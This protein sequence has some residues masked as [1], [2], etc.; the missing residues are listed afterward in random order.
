MPKTAYLHYMLYSTVCIVSILIALIIVWWFS[1]KP[2]TKEDFVIPSPYVVMVGLTADGVV[3]YADIDVPMSPKWLISQ[4]SGTVSDIAGSTGNLYTIRAGGTVEY[5]AYDAAQ[6]VLSGYSAVGSLSIDDDGSILSATTTYAL[7]TAKNVTTAPST[8]NIISANKVSAN[9]GAMFVISSSGALSYYPST[10]AYS[11]LV[12]Y[13]VPGVTSW[14]EVSFDGGVVCALDSAGNVWCADTNVT[15]STANWK[16]QGTKQ[17]KKISLKGNRLVGVAKDDITYYSNSYSSPNWTAL[18][19]MKYD[20]NTGLPSPGA[21]PLT[22]QKVIMMYP[23]LDA[24]RKRFVAG[25]EC[26]DDEQRID[27]FCYMPCASGRAAVGAKCPFRRA[28]T[29]AIAACPSGTEY[30]NGS[31]YKPCTAGTANGQQCIGITTV[32]ATSAVNTNITP[33]SHD[34]PAGGVIN[35]RY[36]RVRPTGLIENNKL[37][38]S[39]IRVLNANGT[40]YITTSMKTFATDGTCLDAPLGGMSCGSQYS[41]YLSGSSFDSD[42]DGGKMSRGSKLYWEVDLGSIQPIKSIQ[43]TGCQ[44]VPFT[45]TNASPTETTSQ[46]NAD[47]ITGMSIELYGR[48]NSSATKPIAVRTLGAD[49]NQTISFN[50]VKASEPELKNRCYDTCP[51]LNGVPSVLDYDSETCVATQGGVTMRSITSP[52]SLPDPVCGPPTFAVTGGNR[53]IIGPNTIQNWTIDPKN[54]SY[55]LSCD[56]FPDTVLTPKV[57]VFSIPNAPMNP[58]NYNDTTKNTAP[59]NNNVITT[60]LPSDTRSANISMMCVRK[61]DI[62]CRTHNTG[63]YTYTLNSSFICENTTQME[64]FY[65]GA[66]QEDYGDMRYGPVRFLENNLGTNGGSEK[67]GCAG[68]TLVY[69]E[70]NDRQ[71]APRIKRRTVTV[72]GSYDGRGGFWTDAG[73]QCYSAV[74]KSIIDLFF[75]DQ[76]TV[77]GNYK[78]PEIPPTEIFIPTIA[79]ATCKCLNSDSTVNKAAYI[80]NGKC[81]KCS[82]RN[83]LFYPR[84]VAQSSYNWS[85]EQKGKWLTAED[86]TGNLVDTFLTPFT[87]I[88]AAKRYCETFPGCK[89]ITKTFDA[90]GDPFYTIRGGTTLLDATSPT[91]GSTRFFFTPRDSSWQILPATQGNTAVKLGKAPGTQFSTEDIPRPFTDD[92]LSSSATTRPGFSRPTGGS[93]TEAVN[94]LTSAMLEF[95][96]AWSIFQDA[97]QNTNNYYEQSGIQRK[98][99]STNA[100][101]SSDKGICVGPCDPEHTLSDP[102]QMTKNGTTGLYTLYGTVCY[103]ASK[104]QFN[105]PSIP[106]LYTPEI[107]SECENGQ[108][109]SG[110]KCVTQCPANSSDDGSSC[111]SQTSPRPFI[112]PTYSCAP[113]LKLIDSVCVQPCGPGYT[114]DADYCIPNIIYLPV[115][116]SINCSMAGSQGTGSQGTG[117]N[118]WLCDSSDDMNALLEGPTDSSITPGTQAYVNRGDSTSSGDILCYADDPTTGMYYCKTAQDLLNGVTTE[119]PA[120]L[121]KSCDNLAK[122]YMDLSNNL[123]IL[124]NSKTTASNASAQIAAVQATL[125]GVISQMCSTSTSGGSSQQCVKLRQQ[126]LMLGSNIGSG[127]GLTSGILSP[128]A[129]ATTSRDQLV[130]ML[131]NFKCC[132]PGQTGYPWCG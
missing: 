67:R 9:G 5:G 12:T 95:A 11:T 71:G 16:K 58:W 107:G 72:M 80:Y 83:D 45:G 52:L 43:F 131:R 91:S 25:K 115:P 103:N 92:Y 130:A 78:S 14:S 84:G 42:P 68:S 125:E 105:R 69:F 13:T 59:G 38:I 27:K 90:A 99:T 73:P 24:R 41:T 33:D 18:P 29:P 75:G 20:L 57:S 47:Q 119:E 132:L 102:L 88:E 93:Y 50:Y 55:Y 126:L 124:M 123:T 64:A 104:V 3:Y 31:C 4:V 36:V 79:A 37:C 28:H 97:A 30:I 49:I 122:A 111:T 129:A 94:Y 101:S 74:K 15:A 46:P 82:G 39:R 48:S 8:I 113:P 2:Y 22:F 76:A 86:S 34:C 62:L 118:K 32:K 26:N 127:S 19:M 65:R 21:A 40:D 100:S 10:S 17:F 56:A 6:T 7:K 54:S 116:S 61:S 114:E 109:L 98:L 66:T 120:N 106:A 23:T 128:I 108:Y 51:P 117:T 96:S 85:A 81:V 60:T 44:Y 1:Q 112:G 89:G 53:I 77:D 35:A 121:S 87:D 110:S 70:E 63:Q